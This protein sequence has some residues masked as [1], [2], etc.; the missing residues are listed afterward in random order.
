VESSIKDILMRAWIAKPNFPA[1]SALTQIKRYFDSD[2]GKWIRDKLDKIDSSSLGDIYEDDNDRLAKHNRHYRKH[3][4]C[5]EPQVGNVY[6]FPK[7]IPKDDFD[8]IELIKKLAFE[9][10]LQQKKFE[11]IEYQRILLAAEERMKKREKD[12]QLVGSKTITR[13]DRIINKWVV[14]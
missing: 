9:K 7:Y 6:N 12:I 5:T 13:N 1:C 2:T 3:V 8:N 4:E 14:K 11:E 10:Q